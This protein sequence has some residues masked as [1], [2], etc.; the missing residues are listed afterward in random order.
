MDDRDK[1]IAGF[2]DAYTGSVGH[3]KAVHHTHFPAPGIELKGTKFVSNYGWV[4]VRP[5]RWRLVR[6]V[7]DGKETETRKWRKVQGAEG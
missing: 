3:E 1:P 7:K 4:M 2:E 6:K 5:G